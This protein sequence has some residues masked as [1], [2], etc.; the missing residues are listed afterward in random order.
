MLLDEASVTGTA[1]IIMA[2]VLAEGTTTIRNAAELRVKESDRI[3]TTVANLRAMGANV[4]EF[5]DGLAVTGGT[6][7]HGATMNSF[8]DH[9]IA[10]GF[11]MAGLQAEG[12]TT[13]L[14]C[15]NI[16]TSYPG[17]DEHL[18]SLLN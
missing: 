2:A 7:L 13:L 14:N 4:E 5:E 1:N 12:T 8:G 17:F 9:R 11:L 16:N 6:P 10:M 18:Q 15:E 3:A